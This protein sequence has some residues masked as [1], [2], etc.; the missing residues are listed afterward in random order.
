LIT[1]VNTLDNFEGFTANLASGT[2]EYTD[3][4]I[5]IS[6]S[7]FYGE[8]DIKDC[9]INSQGETNGFCYKSTK[10]ALI[11][12]QITKNGKPVHAVVCDMPFYKEWSPAS[13]NLRTLYYNN[14]FMYFSPRTREGK[15]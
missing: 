11:N 14:K 12:A 5:E 10:Y 1:D 3:F 4:V 6:D 15:I 8:S 13:W 2:D 7:N 9:P